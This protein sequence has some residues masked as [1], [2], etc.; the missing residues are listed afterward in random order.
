MTSRRVVMLKDALSVLAADASVQLEYLRKLGVPS[1]ID[2]LALEYDATAAAAESML[3][4]GEIDEQQAL[5]VRNL[6]DLLGRMSGETNACLWTVSALVSAKEWQE[7]RAR[8]A[9]CLRLWNCAQER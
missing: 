5:C 4:A 2:E 8:A 9:K 1:A 6:N 7:V 3:D